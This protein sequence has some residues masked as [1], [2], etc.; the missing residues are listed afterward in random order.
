MQKKPQK[1]EFFNY[2]IHFQSL[3]ILSVFISD[4]EKTIVSYLVLQ[5]MKN[6]QM[7]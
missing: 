2:D 5:Q 6:S 1:T 3:C 7:I 4:R